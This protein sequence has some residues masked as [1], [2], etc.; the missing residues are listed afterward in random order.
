MAN[1]TTTKRRSRKQFSLRRVR[2]TPTRSL[3]TLGA[4][5]AIVTGTTG[6]STSAYRA[7][8]LKG[9]WTKSG[10]TL[11][12]GPII[13]GFAHSNYTVTEI[14]ECLESSSSIAVG[15]KIEQ[16]QS[17]RLVRIVGTFGSKTDESLRNGLPVKTRLNWLIPASG[18]GVEVN[19]FAYNDGG[20]A[21]TTGTVIK[22]NGDMWVKDSV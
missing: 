1:K 5:L 6:G 4:N 3:S 21:L 10:G 9:T 18:S 15:L 22:F 14:K 8:S 20:S 7:V 12:E 2:V 17:N 11:G 19:I 13:V 16:E